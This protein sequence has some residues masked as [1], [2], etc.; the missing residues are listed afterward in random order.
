MGGVSLVEI[1]IVYTGKKLFLDMSTEFIAKK[2]QYRNLFVLYINQGWARA[3]TLC[4]K[5]QL[6]FN[7]HIL[8]STLLK[9]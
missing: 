4:S 6:V 1:L 2:G 3:Y 7:T 5:Y 9:L 8:C